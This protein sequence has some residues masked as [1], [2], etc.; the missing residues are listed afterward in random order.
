M[1]F[2]I[3]LPEVDTVQV[4]HNEQTQRYNVG[5]TA[6][7]K[8]T[9]RDGVYHEDVGYGMLENCKSK[10]MALDKVCLELPPS[11][12]SQIVMVL[13]QEGGGYRWHQAD[14]AKLWKSFGQLSI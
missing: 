10:G 3:A 13:V 9:L 14:V 11:L 1:I 8:V 12:R 5:V 7:V 4:D 6:I 2:S